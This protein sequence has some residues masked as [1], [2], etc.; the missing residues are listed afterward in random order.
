MKKIK[1]IAK[2]LIVFLLVVVLFLVGLTTYA[3]IITKPNEKSIN[4][5]IDSF[6]VKN[7]PVKDK[8]TVY[9]NKNMIPFIEAEDDGD[10]AFV[11]GVVHSFLRLGQMEMFRMLAK[12]NLS[13]MA[14]PFTRDIE[15]TFRI[16]NLTKAV[17]ETVKNLPPETKKW[18]ENFVRGINWY[19]D[20]T[21]ELPKEMKLLNI[22]KHKWTVEDVYTVGRL[23]TID[24]TWM[25]YIQFMR[26]LNNP[27]YDYIWENWLK[28]GQNSIPSFEKQDIELLNQIIYGFS[29]SGSNSIVIHKNKS[30]N[31]H[32]LMANDP[33]LGIMA[34]N[35]WL[36]VGLKSP[37]YHTVGLQVP[38]IP[39]T[40]VGRNMHIA[41]GGTNMHSISSHLYEIKSDEDVKF[42]NR[43]DTLKVRGWFDK[44]V[45][46]RECEFGVVISDSPLF[47]DINKTIA[48]KWVGHK[49][50]YELTAFLRANKATNFKEFR[51]A[52]GVYSVAGQNMLYADNDGNIGH[53]LA[54]EQAIL[55]HPEKTLDLIKT[56]DDPIVKTLKPTDLPY[57]YN[58]AIGYIASANN[59][60][61][62]TDVPIAYQY[63]G[64]NRMM[65]LN[66]QL[67]NDSAVSIEKLKKLQFDTHSF[68]NLEVRDL[69]LSKIS[70]LDIKKEYT[71]FWNDFVNWDGD[72]AVDS[73]QPVAFQ[74]LLSFMMNSYLDEKRIDKDTK[75]SMLNGE[76]WLIFIKDFINKDKDIDNRVLLSLKKGNKYYDKYQ[77]WGDMHRLRFGFPFVNI[78]IIGKN[79]EIMN[80]GVGGTGHSLMKTAHN[81]S[82]KK[83]NISYGSQSRHISDMSDVDL[84]YF[85]LLGGQDGWHSSSCNGDQLK[86]W[87]KQEY[88]QVPLR[89]ETVKKQFN[90]RI[91][92]IE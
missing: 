51:D 78:P 21:D 6:P 18:V 65:R 2:Y 79:F 39:I 37:S 66:Q 41:W 73:H 30:F 22:E 9:W 24:L 25:V 4:E 46:I 38:G 26:Q 19:I 31:Q 1:K 29:K 50:T 75:G 89:I 67:K 5:R 82:H 58:P 35:M 28:D 68:L 88:I 59:L 44:T 91:F 49:P 33:H 42:T 64:R 16:F 17:P 61:F 77:T 14:G 80:V 70:K 20:N 92:K 84:N 43:V 11:L 3:T 69:I 47:K 71:D 55:K 34:P 36:L 56:T 81:L 15:H 53:V 32:A 48:L 12:G 60:P 85:V 74:V 23:M 7:Y 83:H 40:A 76:N 8:V 27:Q 72:Y 90:Y 86:L 45:K 10:A 62:D 87:L 13:Q 52:F 57:A 63:D 54:Y